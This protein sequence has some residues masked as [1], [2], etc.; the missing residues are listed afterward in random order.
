[1]LQKGLLEKLSSYVM[2]SIAAKEDIMHKEFIYFTDGCYEKTKVVDEEVS[3]L[4]TEWFV[5]DKKQKVFGNKSGLEYFL[6]TCGNIEEKDRKIYEDILSYEV[7]LFEVISLTKG[8]SV[9]VESLATGKQYEVL[10]RSASEG[11]AQGSIIWTRI[12]SATGVYYMI[13]STIFSADVSLGSGL[14]HMIT[15][16]DKNSFDALSAFRMFIRKESLSTEEMYEKTGVF[17]AFNQGIPSP[18]DELG[19]TDIRNG[20]EYLEK[21]YIRTKESFG[22]VLKQAKMDTIIKLPVFETWVT[23]RRRYKAGFA[24][25]AVFFLAPNELECDTKL[26][27]D[28]LSRATEFS[29]SIAR[30]CLSNKKKIVKKDTH[31]RGRF[32]MD[33]YSHEPYLVHIEKGLRYT[34]EQEFDLAYKEHE[35]CIRLLLKDKVLYFD[36]FRVFCNAGGVKIAVDGRSL[37]GEELMHASLRIND[38]YSFATESLEKYGLG[39]EGGFDGKK[40]SKKEKLAKDMYLVMKNSAERQYSRSVFKKYEDF[41]K[42]SGVSLSYKPYIKPTIFTTDKYGKGKIV[43]RKDPC[44]CGSGEKMKRCKCEEYKDI[45]G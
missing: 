27:E 8:K 30:L 17:Q 10:D 6:A 9:C 37:F 29:N 11:L 26:R 42:S 43:G 14:R 35:A 45:R 12:A 34:K 18:Y 1:M 40:L 36:C 13:G 5:F 2:E 19:I 33:T 4:F 25:R 23:D 31:S 38:Q 16:E 39:I 20:K 7:G 41:L 21:E 15:Q 24:V 32:E 28:L 3:G 44:Q 22:E